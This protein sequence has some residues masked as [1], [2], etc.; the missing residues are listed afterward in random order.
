M[1]G[2]FV[3]VRPYPGRLGA[4]IREAVEAE[5]FILGVNM[6]CP[7]G[8]S[9][10]DAARL[11]QRSKADLLVIPFHLHRGHSGEVLDGIGVL[12]D[13]PVDYRLGEAGLFMPVRAFSWGASFQRRLDALRSQRPDLAARM[14][15]AHQDEIGTATLCARLRRAAH[16]GGGGGITLGPQSRSSVAPPESGSSVAPAESGSFAVVPPQTVSHPPSARKITVPPPAPSPRESDAVMRASDSRAPDTQVPSSGT[17]RTV[18]SPSNAPVSLILP[19]LPEDLGLPR[20]AEESF[21]RAAEIGA[22]ARRQSSGE[23]V[24]PPKKKS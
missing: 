22:R 20:T 23:P 5:G 7:E 9:N 19:R 12:L 13:L 16:Q 10:A 17:W 3:F 2:V 6:L 14:I 11:V 1:A 8:T 15:V 21:R 4:S 18:R 24:R